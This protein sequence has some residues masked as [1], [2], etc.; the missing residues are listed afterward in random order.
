MQSQKFVVTAVLAA[1]LL[2]AIG[3]LVYGWALADFFAANT[4]SATGV[5]KEPGEFWAI[6]VGE[7]SGATLLTLVIAGWAKAS[8]AGEG[9]RV[10]A[11]LGLLMTIAFDF[12][13]FGTS[14]MANLTATCVDVV[15]NTARYTVVGAFIGWMAARGR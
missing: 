7:L 1:V 13:M 10:G 12:V 8:G 15:V 6:I 4:G 14:N 9:A 3:G 2:F 5:M 11:V